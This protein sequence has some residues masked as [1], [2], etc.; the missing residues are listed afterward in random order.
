[1]STGARRTGGGRVSRRGW[2]KL[3]FASPSKSL[4]KDEI[5]ALN[6]KL[7]SERTWN[8]PG[9]LE[10]TKTKLSQLQVPEF[11]HVADSLHPIVWTEAAPPSAGRVEVL[12][13]LRNFL[14]MDR[15]QHQS[16]DRLKERGVE[17]GNGRHSTLQ[18]QERS[19]F[20]QSNIG[21]VLRATLLRLLRDG[22]ECIWDFLS[23]S[24]PSCAETKT[25]SG[26]ETLTVT[27]AMRWQ[28]GNGIAKVNACTFTYL[29]F[30]LFI[31]L[32]STSHFFFNY[33]FIYKEEIG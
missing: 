31:H 30:S 8:T 3:T 20:T 33:S 1:M 5:A 10:N 15:P 21:T 6:R 23:A 27:H 9:L 19:V 14:N 4:Y 16:I 2:G 13:G 17:K 25:I 24:M 12:R 28:P 7:L 22:V 18:G 11:W 32:V 29:Y 26:H